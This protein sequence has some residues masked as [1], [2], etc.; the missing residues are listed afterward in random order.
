MKPLSLLSKQIG[1]SPTIA[2]MDKARKLVAEG[3]DVIG[4]AGGEPDFDTPPHVIEAGIQAIRDG[5]THYASPS[6]GITP[7]L[8]AIAKK[9]ERDSHIQV[10][11]ATDIVVTPGA[12]WALYLSLQT[13]LDREDEVLIPE[14]SWVSYPA[15]VKMLGATPV[16]VPLDSDDNFRITADRL[17]EYL[18]PKTKV[19]MINTPTNPTGRVL[20]LEEIQAI[21]QVAQEADLYVLSDEIYE[22][23]IFD[24]HT[25]ISIASQAGMAER[26]ITVNGMSKAFAMTGWRMGWLAAPTPIA[27]LASIFN[28][29]TVTSAATFT[30]HAT[31]A[32]L[33][34]DQDYV[35]MMRREYQ[36]RRD[37]IV[38]ALNEIDGIH[39]RSIEGTFY[40]FPSF[41][42]T[43][44][45]SDEIADTL[46]QKAQVVG[47]PGTA[48]GNSA[49]GHVRFSIA[50]DIK[51]LERAVERIASVAS[52][53]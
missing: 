45:T 34:G 47:V 16:M 28:T 23:V 40:V 17:R 22:K 27:K 33:N 1:A 18:S 50:T 41:P 48:F 2:L 37:V 36:T 49:A 11:P 21:S 43:D 25:H 9:L 52:E 35:E 46:L 30:M 3:Q 14:P 7:L 15:M 10:N 26:T 39:C 13:L 29:Q 53:I 6:K 31:V 20:S 5:Y 8:E 38:N 19:I 44:K 32:A 12:K 42:N 4:L 51:E 24:G